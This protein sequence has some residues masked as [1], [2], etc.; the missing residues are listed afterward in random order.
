MDRDTL[1]KYIKHQ[2]YDMRGRIKSGNINETMQELEHEATKATFDDILENFSRYHAIEC[3]LRA[4]VDRPSKV[5]RGVM[6]SSG[7]DWYMTAD[8]YIKSLPFDDDD[9]IILKMAHG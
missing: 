3:F 8:E 6:K 7:I 5:G 1:R 4:G 2:W 9:K